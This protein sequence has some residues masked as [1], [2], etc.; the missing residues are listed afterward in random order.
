MC[1]WQAT[2]PDP[3]PH[4]LDQSAETSTE[5]RHI[6]FEISKMK[7]AL[8]LIRNDVYIKIGW[9]PWWWGVPSFILGHEEKK[10][11]MPLHPRG[12]L[13]FVQACDPEDIFKL[14]S[15]PNVMLTVSGFC[16]NLLPSVS[17][18]LFTFSSVSLFYRS[19]WGCS[20]NSNFYLNRQIPNH[21]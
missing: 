9:P 20:L 16:Q 4:L 5:R 10:S 1:D 2:Q 21:S 14:F 3:A 18:W 19:N 12:I 8:F 7:S 13:E 6:Y 11:R 15:Y 17:P